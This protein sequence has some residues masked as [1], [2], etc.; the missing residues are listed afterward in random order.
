M[1]RTLFLIC[2]L[3]ASL[4]VVA[5]EYTTRYQSATE[6]QTLLPT[7]YIRLSRTEIILPS[8]GTYNPYKADLHIHSTLTD[9]VL[10]IKGRVEEAWCDGLDVIAATEH[11][12]I[13]PVADTEGQPTPEKV[14]LKKSS[15]AVKAVASATK[16]AENFGMVVI[17]GVELTG[18]AATQG[19]FNALF[20]TDNSVIYDYDAM[21]SI[22]N[23]DKQG[24]LIMHN[25][26]GWRHPTLEMTQFEKDVYAEG[27]V[28]GLE[29]MNGAYFYPR[30]FKTAKEHKLF[31][32]SNTDIHA[33][34][35]QQY[36]ENGHLRNMTIIFAQECTLESLRQ[37]LEA[38]RTICYSFGTI[39]GDEKLLK[40]FFE[41]S[42]TTQK[43]NI[44]KKKNVQRVK[45]TNTTS[46]P[47]VIRIGKGNAVVLR[48]LSST[49]VTGKVGKPLKC[50][51]LNMYCG[52][53]EHPIVT[54]K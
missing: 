46:L 17:P 38:H 19:H 35:G 18:D 5:Q 22:R 43:L 31:M 8:L 52:Q 51:V 39:G 25:H 4:S 14:R 36:R 50:T 1:K 41:A 42:V 27:L 26:P 47:Y 10:N 2:V 20:T 33:T 16:V 48:P 13:R 32:T 7:G 11:M 49:I 54:I 44:D 9:G 37:A 3:L 6:P 23:A 40:E 21:Q 30:A 34:T 45:V 29:L 24:A 53:D 15:A 12:S 28:D